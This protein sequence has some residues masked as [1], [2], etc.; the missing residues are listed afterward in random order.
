MELLDIYSQDEEET[1][2]I[3]VI[4]PYVGQVSMLKARFIEKEYS[5]DFQDRVEIGTVHT[6]QGSE[7]DVIIFDIVD[8]SRFEKGKPYFGRIYSGEQGEQLLNV[9]IS[10][11]RHKLIVVCDP[12][13]ITKCPGGVVTDKTISIFNTLLKARWTKM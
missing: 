4:T 7:C 11:A 5:L 9:A 13:F 2:S 1:F 6:F 12:E 8:C 10:R 3:G